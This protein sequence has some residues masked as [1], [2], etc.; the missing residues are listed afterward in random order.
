MYKS[1]DYESLG[2]ELIR[3]RMVSVGYPRELLRYTY[4]PSFP[5][6]SVHLGGA[7]LRRAFQ[8]E[9]GQQRLKKSLNITTQILCVIFTSP[10][11]SLPTVSGLV[12][13]TLYGNL[14]KVDSNGNI[15]VCSHGFRFLRR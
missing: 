13:D 7:T 6:R 9:K 3:D 14:L 1:P 4:D 10:L 2:F 5:T 11:L 15:L 8:D 12:I